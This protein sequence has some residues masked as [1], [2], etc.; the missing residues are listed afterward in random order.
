MI[1]PLSL[2][3]SDHRFKLNTVEPVALLTLRKESHTGS[4]LWGGFIKWVFICNLRFGIRE[5][6]RI[7]SYLYDL[8]HQ[9][10]GLWNFSL[11]IL[12]PSFS[13][14]ELIKEGISVLK[15]FHLQFVKYLPC[16]WC[17]TSSFSIPLCP[18]K[19][20]AEVSISTTQSGNWAREVHLRSCV[21]VIQLRFKRMCHYEN[22][23]L[24]YDLSA[25][26]LN[27]VLL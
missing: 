12:S 1:W 22:F 15:F 17:S 7:I 27:N 13:F 23:P 10:T 8:W 2:N 26:I 9:R 5:D 19:L 20:A 24:P 4:A 18:F 21:H 3:V 11:S 6:I 14:S 25:S 16:A